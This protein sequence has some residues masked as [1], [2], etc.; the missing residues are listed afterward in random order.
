MIKIVGE[1]ALEKAFNTGELWVIDDVPG[2]P[3][4]DYY[5][6]KS[7]WEVFMKKRKDQALVS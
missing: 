2:D 5:V 1:K 4:S 6:L 7:D 3:D